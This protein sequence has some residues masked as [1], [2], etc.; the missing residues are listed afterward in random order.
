MPRLLIECDTSLCFFKCFSLS[1][2]DYIQVKGGVTF[3]ITPCPFVEI[4]TA[5]S[6]VLLR[7]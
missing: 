7:D 4:S 5:C 6:S 2:K 3:C 1:F